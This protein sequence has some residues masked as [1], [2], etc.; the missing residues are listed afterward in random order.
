MLLI[1]K[2]LPRIPALHLTC[3]RMVGPAL[4]QKGILTIT[5]HVPTILWAGAV[6]LVMLIYK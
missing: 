6:K 1:L 2:E 3:V 5:V 4:L